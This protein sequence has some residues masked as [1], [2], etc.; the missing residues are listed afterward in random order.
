M[1]LKRTSTAVWHGKGPTGSGTITTLSGAFKDQPYSVN[2]RFTSED[3]KAGTNPE[4]LIAAAHA[5]CFTMA[6]AFQITNGG[7]E[8]TKLETTAT[9]AMEKQDIGWTIVSIH[10]ELAGE[11]PGITADEFKTF[12]ENA[13]KGCPIS[14]A[15]AAVS[16]ITMNAT[17][18]S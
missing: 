8:P 3:G 10:L 12:A 11:V 7:K 16:T 6:T 4:E 9:V 2:T 1:A 13:K 14:R 18:S 5:S 15:L 17:L